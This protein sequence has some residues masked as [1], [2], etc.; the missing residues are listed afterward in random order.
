MKLVSLWFDKTR[1]YYCLPS[2]SETKNES[3]IPPRGLHLTVRLTP[4]S[5]VLK[6]LKDCVKDRVTATTGILLWLVLLG[7]IMHHTSQLFFFSKYGDP[8]LTQ[9]AETSL[10]VIYAKLPSMADVTLSLMFTVAF[11]LPWVRSNVEWREILHHCFS[12]PAAQRQASLCSRVSLCAVTHCQTDRV[13]IV[14]ALDL[15]RRGLC[16]LRS[17]GKLTFHQMIQ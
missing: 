14:P 5:S 12:L 10:K 1:P 16:L 9:R 2:P 17:S 11:H 15:M 8:C 4:Q 7:T 6:T 3:I 13:I